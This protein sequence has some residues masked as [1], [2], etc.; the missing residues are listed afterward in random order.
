M[1]IVTDL[2]FLEGAAHIECC[3][4]STGAPGSTG[5]YIEN[6]DKAVIG[7]MTAFE[8]SR[9]HLRSLLVVGWEVLPRMTLLCLHFEMES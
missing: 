7:R 8:S 1:E 2:Q 4:L 6:V 5:A 3:T 9:F